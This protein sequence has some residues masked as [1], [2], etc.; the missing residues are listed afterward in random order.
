[1]ARVE[2]A[3]EAEVRVA[4]WAVERVVV[5]RVAAARAAAWAVAKV[6]AAGAVAKTGPSNRRQSKT[7]RRGVVHPVYVRGA[8]AVTVAWAAHQSLALR[9]GVDVVDCRPL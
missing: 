8:W 3:R 4:A 7:R 5:E 1:M 2:A 6:A 9:K